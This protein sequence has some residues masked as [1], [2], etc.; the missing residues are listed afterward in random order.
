MDPHPIE[1][2]IGIDYYCTQ[3]PGIGGKLRTKIEDFIVEEIG[4]NGEILKLQ[5]MSARNI[6]DVPQNLSTYNLVLEKYNLETFYAIHQIA[7]QLRTPYRN[8]GFAGLKDKRALTSQLIS[9]SGVK[10]PQL[11]KI[12]RPN[13][14]LNRIR[15]GKVIK[16]G[17]LNG[18]H[19]QITIRNCEGS[20]NEI[21]TKIDQITKIVSTFVP[22]YYGPQRFGALR[23]ISHKLGRALLVD[24]Y[25]SA[26]K[27][28][29]T[30]LFPQE[31]KK[32]QN[33]RRNIQES[34]PRIKSEF[35]KSCFYEN[36]IIQ[37]LTEQN[38]NFKKI[39]KKVFPHRYLLLFIHALQSFI[40]NK[41]L[42]YRLS[43][44]IPLNQALEG[45]YVAI[46]DQYSLPTHALYEV[47]S[48]TIKS[49]NNAIAKKKAIVMAP[50][51][52][53]DF[54]YSHHPLAAEISQI[55]TENNINLSLFKSSSNE[56]LHLKTTFRPVFFRPFNFS[57]NVEDLPIDTIVRVN[58]SL[59]KGCY[60]TVLLREFMKTSPLSY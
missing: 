5:Q 36:R 58:F 7:T 31:D 6:K 42:N 2:V 46:L 49:L 13:I 3:I 59:I 40:F 53:Y 9:I 45:E 11:L 30:A 33:I 54:K 14:Y 25:E 35:P 15:P 27:I 39:F 1:K 12:E 47:N 32:I 55:F 24:D 21:A 52:G 41:L 10:L 22:N 4:I 29:L 56:K 57:V 8:I 43:L 34:W 16:L 23:P 38:P 51:I 50:L 19:F 48:R 26:L 28:Y 18:N 44:E 20:Y 37:Q 17:F 60:A